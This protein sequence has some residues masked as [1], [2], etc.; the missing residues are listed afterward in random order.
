[1]TDWILAIRAGS[2]RDMMRLHKT[3]TPPPRDMYE[4]AAEHPGPG[5]LIWLFDRG[6]PIDMTSPDIGHN[7]L[8]NV[9]WLHDHGVKFESWNLGSA[10]RG[11]DYEMVRWLH[12]HGGC[13]WDKYACDALDRNMGCQLSIKDRLP[14]GMSEQLFSTFHWFKDSGLCRCGG[15]GATHPSAELIA[16]FTA[17][18]QPPQVLKINT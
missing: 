11:G 6:Y 16:R 10:A 4:Y 14:R 17:A 8:V 1:M 12:G 13:E 9:K 18:A 3:K 5:M 2:Y 7:P 15:S